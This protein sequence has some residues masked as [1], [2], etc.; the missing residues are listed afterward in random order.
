MVT[1]FGTTSGQIDSEGLK[2]DKLGIME[3]A[4]AMNVR[5]FL[6]DVGRLSQLRSLLKFTV[7]KLRQAKD[8]CK[9]HVVI[10]KE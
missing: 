10:R 3:Q 1:A 7:G 9:S 2:I 8:R 5:Q 4:A 6:D